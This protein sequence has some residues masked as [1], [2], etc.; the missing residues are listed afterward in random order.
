MTLS[1]NI[2][3]EQGG[4]TPTFMNMTESTPMTNVWVSSGNDQ[5]TPIT[6]DSDD[7][8]EQLKRNRLT[9]IVWNHYKRQKN[10]WYHE[11]NM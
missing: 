2:E 5:S 9:S 10:K 7:N 4:L 8:D 11:S 1:N 3:L 6:W